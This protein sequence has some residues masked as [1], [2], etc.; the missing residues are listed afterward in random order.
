MI[1]FKS[2]AKADHVVSSWEV[3]VAWQDP[4]MPVHALGVLYL[5]NNSQ[6]RALEKDEDT[7]FENGVRVRIK[8]DGPKCTFS[9]LDS[10][11][12]TQL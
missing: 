4:V 7:G 11:Q 9:I 10:K 5:R 6:V 8:A 3:L 1:E 12:I 2:E